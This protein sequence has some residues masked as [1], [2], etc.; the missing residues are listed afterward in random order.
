M[1]VCPGCKRPLEAAEFY[2]DARNRDGLYTYCRACHSQKVMARKRLLRY[3]EGDLEIVEMFKW[4]I[5]KRGKIRG[6]HSRTRQG[7]KVH[8]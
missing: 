5:K 6:G 3:C 1:K 4:V 8:N 2:R 7:A